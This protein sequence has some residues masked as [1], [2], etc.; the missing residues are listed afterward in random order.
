[1]NQTGGFLECDLRANHDD[2]GTLENFEPLTVLT[3]IISS[4][5]AKK[6]I[7]QK[8]EK[9]VNSLQGETPNSIP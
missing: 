9:G 2:G 7:N 3:L 6:A 5:L 8:D 1:V 4:K